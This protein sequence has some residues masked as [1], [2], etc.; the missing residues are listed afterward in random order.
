MADDRERKLELAKLT[1]RVETRKRNRLLSTPE[2][3]NTGV[4]ESRAIE[5]VKK[6]DP[7]PTGPFSWLVSPILS[8]VRSVPP[9]HRVWPV[10]LILLLSGGA[11]A[12]Y[13]GLL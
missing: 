5:R 2:E 6:S 11:L 7:P 4:I 10:M 13:F 12:R 8:L 1:E 9:Q 3:E